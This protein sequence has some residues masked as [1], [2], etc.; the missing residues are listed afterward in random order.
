MNAAAPVVFVVDDDESMRTALR[1]LLTSAGLPVEVFPTARAFLDSPRPDAPACLVLDVRLPDLNGL[2]L[3]RHLTQAGKSLPIVFLTG[4]GD[5]PMSVRAM[6]AGAVEFLTKPFRP[7]EL[8]E[9][10]RHALDAERRIRE[11]VN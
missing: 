10:I 8:L 3:Q 9:A 2:E 11:S 7:H 6:K 5:I 1:R 4:H